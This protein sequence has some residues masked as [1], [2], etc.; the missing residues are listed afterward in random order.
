VRLGHQRFP[1]GFVAR[2][3]RALVEAA[4]KCDSRFA[5]ER[6]DGLRGVEIGGA[7]P[8]GFGLDTINVDRAD[9]DFYRRE[10]EEVVGWA[11]PVDVRADGDALP[12]ADDAHDF[13][14]ASHVIEHMPD[15]IAALDEWCRVAARYVFLVVPHRDRT[16]DRGRPLTPVQELVDRHVRGFR[17]DEDRHWSVW[18]CESFLELC[19]HVGVPVLEFQDPDDVGRNGFAVLLDASGATA[20][21]GP[22]TRRPTPPRWRR[23]IILGAG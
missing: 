19:A 16:F 10:Q 9:S 22:R 20:P 5:H 17:S 11:M 12:F 23:P 13:V 21:P 14:L 6:L 8:Q 18:T 15:P 2:H 7:A 1:L 3:P 4:L